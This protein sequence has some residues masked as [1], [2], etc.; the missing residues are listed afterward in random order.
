MGQGYWLV[1][2]IFKNIVEEDNLESCTKEHRE[3]FMCNIRARE[4]ILLALL[5][6]E[7][8]Q[9]KLLKTSY[10]I[11]KALE[12]NYE[13]DTHAKRVGLQNLHCAFQ[14]AKMMEDEFVRSYIMNIIIF[15]RN[16]GL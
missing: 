16:Q 4:A 13:G 11:W 7:Y 3:V 15:C 6:S 1:T 9:V 14:D 8:S 5:E 10:E 12:E 2:K